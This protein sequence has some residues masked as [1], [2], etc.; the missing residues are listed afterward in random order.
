MFSCKVVPTGSLSV[1]SSVTLGL[2]I[3]TRLGSLAH[4]T[5][6]TTRVTSMSRRHV[7]LRYTCP[8]NGCGVMALFVTRNAG[9]SDVSV[10]KARF[11]VI[12][13]IVHLHLISSEYFFSL[14]VL[15]DTNAIFPE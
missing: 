2:Q 7:A 8:G 12:L 5:G 10:E 13:R 3:V 11:F 14:S 15:S 6:V 1:R 4:K 9:S